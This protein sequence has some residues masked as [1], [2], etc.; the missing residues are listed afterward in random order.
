MK[1]MLI[2][3]KLMYD[4]ILSREKVTSPKYFRRVRIAHLTAFKLLTSQIGIIIG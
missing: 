1:K 2:I 4:I 3:K